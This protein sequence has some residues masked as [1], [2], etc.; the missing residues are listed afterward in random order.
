MNDF[1][2]NLPQNADQ[3]ELFPAVQKPDLS[4]YFLVRHNNMIVGFYDTEDK[5]NEGASGYR[6]QAVVDFND[7]LEVLKITT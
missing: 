7:T 4:S 6:M 3:T 2:I 5:A 1:Q